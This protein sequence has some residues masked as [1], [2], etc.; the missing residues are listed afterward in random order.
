[1]CYLSCCHGF[2]MLNKLQWTF[3]EINSQ[4]W[5]CL[6][7]GV[8]YFTFG[9]IFLDHFLER[10]L[11]EKILHKEASFLPGRQEPGDWQGAPFSCPSLSTWRQ[12]SGHHIS[13]RFLVCFHRWEPG[14][15]L[16]YSYVFN[17]KI[18]SI[19]PLNF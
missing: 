9:C 1:M 11:I 4:K 16:N 6:A 14:K 19:S 8:A 13:S 5:E 3:F 17:S 12:R 2:A 10:R 7:K 15:S 18:P